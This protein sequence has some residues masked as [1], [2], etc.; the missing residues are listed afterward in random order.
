MGRVPPQFG[1]SRPV[2][3]YIARVIR[4]DLAATPK[5]KRAALEQDVGA[6]LTLSE[7]GEASRLPPWRERLLCREA[8]KPQSGDFNYFYEYSLPL[9][10]RL[11]Q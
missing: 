4:Q 10:P 6:L 1:R 8:G 5:R 3:N 9:F 7:R 11:Q 2:A